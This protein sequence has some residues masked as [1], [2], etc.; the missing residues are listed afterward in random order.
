VHVEHAVIV[1]RDQRVAGKSS[2]ATAV[3]PAMDLHLPREIRNMPGYIVAGGVAWVIGLLATAVGGVLSHHI[4]LPVWVVLLI[5]AVVGIGVGLLAYG[6]QADREDATKLQGALEHAETRA[7]RAEEAARTAAAERSREPNTRAQAVL[8]EIDGLT[9]EIAERIKPYAASA[10]VEAT[11]QEMMRAR[12]IRKQAESF[13]DL[14][15][16]DLSSLLSSLLP[17]FPT[18]LPVDQVTSAL[19]QF[20]QS[21][22][23]WGLANPD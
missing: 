3:F 21:V 14:Q 6:H 9:D 10:G 22:T 13:L 20:R 17:N 18:V 5:V 12:Y 15:P 23:S 8:R 7:E 19:N 16:G 11:D 4:T 1:A 2:A